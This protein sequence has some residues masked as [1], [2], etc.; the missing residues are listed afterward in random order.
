MDN[1]LIAILSLLILLGGCSLRSL[2]VRMASPLV[3]NQFA[4]INEETDPILAEHAI[5]AS[6][7]MLEGL[8]REDPDNE[9]VLSRR[10]EGYCGYAF[11]FAEDTHP[12][13]ASL[14]YLRGRD[15]AERLL[16]T[17][18]APENLTRQNPEQFKQS[19]QALNADHR[20]GLY[21]MSQCWA[22]WLMLN[23][24][25]LQAFVAMA[26]VEPAMQRMLEL[27]AS[28]HFAGP[29]LFFGVFYGGRPKILGGNPDKSRQHFEMC[30][31][32]TERKY[33]ITQLLYAKIYAVQIQDRELFKKLL[34]EVLAAPVDILPEQR[35]ANAVAKMKAQTLLE[36]ADDLF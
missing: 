8:L 29:H 32:L 28:Y 11:S 1:K 2:S 34:S 6:L 24:D 13:R 7:K 23:L 12:E 14:L 27:D 30:L 4:A 15:F 22:S 26:K 35:L 5:P 33:L 17:A 20:N 18:G 21:W 3:E 16:V 9:I 10:A 19:V 25:D 31:K 36:S